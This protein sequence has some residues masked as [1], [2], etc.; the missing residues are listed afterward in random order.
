[1]VTRER[2]RVIV[3]IKA[4]SDHARA[5]ALAHQPAAGGFPGGHATGQVECL[6]ALFAQ[7]SG[8]SARTGSGS[9]GDD[10]RSTLGESFGCLGTHIAQRDMH[11]SGDMADIPLAVITDIEQAGAGLE[12]RH[13]LIGLHRWEFESVEKS[14]EW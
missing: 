11:G 3:S 12:H 6:D 14:H 8:C 7:D 9:A 2:P 13:C 10:D 4:L 1:M 5:F